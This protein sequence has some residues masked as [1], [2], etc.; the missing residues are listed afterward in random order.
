MRERISIEQVK[1][2][3]ADFAAYM[4]VEITPR[5]CAPEGRALSPDM[6]TDRERAIS[7]RR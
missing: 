7:N 6:P 3:M 5:H 2:G 1:H 4:Q